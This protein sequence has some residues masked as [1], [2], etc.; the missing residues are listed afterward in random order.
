[1]K[2]TEYVRKQQLREVRMVMRSA[3]FDPSDYDLDSMTEADLKKI[4]AAGALAAAPFISGAKH[5][6]K[7]PE[8]AKPYTYHYSPIFHDAQKESD[9]R[10]DKDYIKFGGKKYEGGVK[11]AQDF[12]K[13]RKTKDHRDILRKAGLPD[14]YVPTPIRSFVYGAD[15]SSKTVVDTVE[16]QLLDKDIK[17]HFGR[18]SFVQISRSVDVVTGGTTTIATI[19]GHTMA[20]NEQEAKLRARM[21]VEHILKRHGFSTDGMVEL[22]G[23]LPKVSQDVTR[24]TI[25]MAREASELTRFPFAF[26]VKLVKESGIG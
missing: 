8:P 11:E 16:A 6:E 25:D 23:M 3:G 14:D 18:D 5:S 13:F 15:V 22:S 10:A 26:K 24:S 2:F 4:L 17:R 1:M 7:P 12:I 21:Q 9:L 20:R 19:Q